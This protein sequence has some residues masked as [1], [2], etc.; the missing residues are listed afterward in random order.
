MRRGSDNRVDNIW[1]K[2]NRNNKRNTEEVVNQSISTDSRSGR[3]FR[4]GQIESGAVQLF[5]LSTTEYI[6]FGMN[7]GGGTTVA[8]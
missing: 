5:N 1:K 4:N 7:N 8:P 2:I 3:R 6:T